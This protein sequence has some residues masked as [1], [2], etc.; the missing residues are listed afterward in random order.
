MDN[1]Y[2]KYLK[3]KNKYLELKRANGGSG[4]DG[5]GCVIG[6]GGCIIRGGNRGVIRDDGVIM[7]GN[8]TEKR[9]VG[10]ELTP[11]NK[12]KNPGMFFNPSV[13]W[14]IRNTDC[15]FN[16]IYQKIPNKVKNITYN[17]FLRTNIKH[18]T[19]QISVKDLKDKNFHVSMLKDFPPI[20]LKNAEYNITDIM[21]VMY[22]HEQISNPSFSL[23]NIKKLEFEI[24][25]LIDGGFDIEKLI[26]AGFTFNEL[27]NT[28]YMLNQNYQSFIPNASHKNINNGFIQFIID[29]N[30]TNLKRLKKLRNLA[31]IDKFMFNDEEI[32][33]VGFSAR[34]LINESYT[35]EQIKKAGYT[36]QDFYNSG[37]SLRALITFGF[38]YEE[39]EHIAYLKYNYEDPILIAYNLLY[40]DNLNNEELKK[41]SFTEEQI[42]KAKSYKNI[43]R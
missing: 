17:D 13:W 43:G 26:R 9:L 36:C 1:Y 19:Q 7:G 5:S 39:L 6:S 12:V 22:N 25:E 8:I 16:K 24:I 37:Y 14:Y 41:M 15:D 4:V 30:P 18:S 38:S 11:C 34:T 35:L 29:F 2:T 27:K 32:L 28:Y 31:N 33:T 42:V 10:G 40:T 21:S 3:Y 20:E 23:E